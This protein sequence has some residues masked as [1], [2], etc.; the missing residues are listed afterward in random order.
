MKT[1]R[2]SY[3]WKVDLNERFWRGFWSWWLA[4]DQTCS[5]IGVFQCCLV[6]CTNASSKLKVFIGSNKIFLFKMKKA[7]MCSVQGLW[8]PEVG[9]GFKESCDERKNG[10]E[11]H[12]KRRLLAFKNAIISACGCDSNVLWVISSWGE[13]WLQGMQLFCIRSNAIHSNLSRMAKLQLNLMTAE[14]KRGGFVTKGD[15]YLE[16]SWLLFTPDFIRLPWFWLFGIY[17]MFGEE[18]NGW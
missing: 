8:K 11:K 13:V 16:D 4:G 1:A 17:L 3:C 6:Q 12:S 15:G 9:A 7:E 14:Q 2:C 18:G 5:A 10:G